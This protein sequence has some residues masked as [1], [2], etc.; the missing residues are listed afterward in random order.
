MKKDIKLMI[1]IIKAAPQLKFGIINTMLSLSGGICIEL[2][3]SKFFEY[4]FLGLLFLS[5]ATEVIYQSIILVS[6]SG[7]G[8]TSSSA[9][10]LQVSFPFYL[11]LLINSIFFFFISIHRVYIASN[12]ALELSMKENINMQC[13]GIVFFSALCF[14]S[15]IFNIL[16][17][18]FFS[19]SL[20]GIISFSVTYMIV[21][22]HSIKHPQFFYNVTVFTF[23]T[24]ITS[25]FLIIFAGSL[26][27]LLV[28][29][30]L[31]KYPLSAHVIKVN[32]KI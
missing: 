13:F 11:Q 26:L 27:S 15:S 14:I 12:P 2:A 5:N 25:G 28:A 9:K 10:K 18:K 24:A 8:Q 4:N 16:S 20:V 3:S 31:Y 19:L 22:I 1:S 7:L 32:N 6:C 29:N 23:P 21:F 17:K 30:L